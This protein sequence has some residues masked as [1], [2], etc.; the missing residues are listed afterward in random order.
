MNKPKYLSF[1]QE[2]L[3]DCLTN[4]NCGGGLDSFSY[5]KVQNRNTLLLLSAL[6]QSLPDLYKKI[7]NVTIF[8][9]NDFILSEQVIIATIPHSDPSLPRAM[10]T[11]MK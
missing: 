2:D 7:L 3:T 10:P 1:E 9:L 5:L 8:G 4:P 11:T 6:E